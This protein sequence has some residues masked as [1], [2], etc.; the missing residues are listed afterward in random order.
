VQALPF[1]PMAAAPKRT[2]K[3]QG[4]ASGAASSGAGATRGAHADDVGV[5]ALT[6]DLT[7]LMAA[8]SG[9]ARCCARLA[10]RWCVACTR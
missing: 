4:A 7:R 6:D 3:R 10:C 8:M 9:G 2:K 1:D 5:A